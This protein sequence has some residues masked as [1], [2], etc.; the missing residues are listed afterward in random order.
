MDIHDR[1]FT[2]VQANGNEHGRFVAKTPAR[3]AQKAGNEILK[4]TKKS[5]V[6]VSI[7]ETT[8]GAKSREPRAYRI[9][10]QRKTAPVSTEYATFKFDVTSKSLNRK[11]KSKSKPST[12]KK[13]AS[14]PK[15]S[16]PTKA[17]KAA[18]KPKASTP[19]KAGKAVKAASKPKA[20]TPKK[21][22]KA[23]KAASK[24]KA[25]KPKKATK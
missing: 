22:V 19:K 3:A 11:S 18:A 16:T 25:S 21:A 14:K 1:S 24:P 23:G 20:S 12:P 4:E 15:A 6:D 7:R 13:A 5:A 8:R 17:V 2:V 10:R 9:Q